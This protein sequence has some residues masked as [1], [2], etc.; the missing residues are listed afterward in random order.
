MVCKG[1]Q[2][3]L[4]PIAP[5]R[6]PHP[7][8]GAQPSA[9]GPAPAGGRGC[10]PVLA[11]TSSRAGL[12]SQRHT[13]RTHRQIHRWDI[14]TGHTGHMDGTHRTRRQDTQDTQ[15][16]PDSAHPHCAPSYTPISCKIP[17]AAGIQQP[18]NHCSYTHSLLFIV[19]INANLSAFCLPACPAQ[20]GSPRQPVLCGAVLF[21]VAG[22]GVGGQGQ[23]WLQGG[24]ST[25]GGA[26]G[27]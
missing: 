24:S 7:A 4:S 17:V 8:A 1:C 6:T 20:A 12:M 23:L 2:E 18:N 25:G 19:L 27:R 14:W 13:D 11:S 5:A 21:C 10:C 15:H 16:S 22:F 3:P 9:R 26:G